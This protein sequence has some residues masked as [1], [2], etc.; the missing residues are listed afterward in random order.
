MRRRLPRDR[1]LLELFAAPLVLAAYAILAFGVFR[2]GCAPAFEDV[3][4]FGVPVTV[5]LLGAL[6]LAALVLI[7][8]AGLH[9]PRVLR[10]AETTVGQTPARRTAL[11][12]LGATLVVASF[13][14]AGAWG[15]LLLNTSCP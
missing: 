11:I 2:L 5:F 4:F 1:S 9:L 6:T 10:R 14:L 13:L 7:L 8:F 3:D 12:L 15:M